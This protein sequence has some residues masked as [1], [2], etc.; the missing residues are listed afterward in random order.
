M[1]T[2]TNNL[3]GTA[4]VASILAAGAF[5][6]IAPTRASAQAPIAAAAKQ[7]AEA[8]LAA[9]EKSEHAALTL[10]AKADQHARMAK[11]YRARSG[12]GSKQ[13]ITFWSLANR[14]ERLAKAERDA[15]L[16]ARNTAAMHRK[17][18]SAE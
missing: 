3:I 12:G 15:A 10:E 8:E 4:A 7:G 13:E 18:A 16:T 1:K 9:A 5:A 17:L 2:Y 6:L 11:L 14:L